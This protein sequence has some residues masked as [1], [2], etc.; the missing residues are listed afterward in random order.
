MTGSS[1]RQ[2]DSAATSSITAESEVMSSTDRQVYTPEEVALMLGMHANSVYALLK[3][4]TLPG[5]KAG[6]RWLISKR[7]FDAWLEGE[8]S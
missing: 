3:E 1:I 8:G 6:R 2:P 5:L 7:R 4:G